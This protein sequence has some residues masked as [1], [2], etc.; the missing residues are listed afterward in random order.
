MRFPGG[1]GLDEVRQRSTAAL[2]SVASRHPDQTVALV[3]HTVVN[4][5]L[6]CAVLGLGN[7]HFWHVAQDTCAVNLIEWDGRQHRLVMMN[8]TSHLWRAE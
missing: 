2:Q 7:D 8:D 4:Q 6:L 3:A 5:V 1:E